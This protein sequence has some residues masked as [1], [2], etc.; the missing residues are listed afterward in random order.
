MDYLERTKQGTSFSGSDVNIFR[1]YAIASGLE[2]Y[3]KTGGM[4]INR[5]YTPKNMLAAVKEMTGIQFKRGQYLEAARALR[6]L[7]EAAK[8]AP[9]RDDATAHLARAARPLEG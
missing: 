1:A 3:V 6:E 4:R 8:A 7:A 2:F 9:R 5:S